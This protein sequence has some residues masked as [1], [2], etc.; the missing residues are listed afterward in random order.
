MT[1][2]KLQPT[3]ET[4]ALSEASS[5]TTQLSAA[6]RPPLAPVRQDERIIAL[7]TVRG[8]AL[9]GILLLNILAFALPDAAAYNP[10]IAGGATRWNFR[11]WF[12]VS[13]LFD[14]KLRTIFSMMFGASVY[15]LGERLSRKGAAGEAADIHYRRLLWMMLF[16]LI[17][18]Y[19][20]WWGDVLYYYAIAGLFLYPLR[21]LSAR[22]LLM[23]A[24]IML[25]AMPCRTFY[26][27]F[28][29]RDL[30]RQVLQVEA[31]QQAGKKLTAD[32]EKTKKEWNDL[33]SDVTPSADQLRED[34]ESHHGSWIA[35]FKGR[36]QMVGDGH[37]RLI[38]L[39]GPW[40][41]V[42]S[43]MLIGMAL[44]K[45]GV[46]SGERSYAFYGWMTTVCCGIGSS[47]AFLST[48]IPFKGGFTPEAFW[49]GFVFYQPG[50][51]AGL[52]YC[53]ILIMMVK[54]GVLRSFTSRLAAVG[55]TAFTNYI[56]TTVICTTIFENYGFGL[57]GKLQRWQLYAIVLGVWILQMAASPIWL[58]YYRFGPMEWL[59]R[60]LTYWKKQPM[61][62]SSDVRRTKT[63]IKAGL[64]TVAG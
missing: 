39:P 61:R 14:G 22:A 6:H 37:G 44:I 23:A 42:V 59:W 28:H 45:M 10:N 49:L 54:A 48:W 16:G 47:C 51:L 1:L 53:A 36:A 3:V 35:L 24:A 60:S 57:Y 63:P 15:M 21:K 5:R 40:W 41:D 30:H 19:L 7:D 50:R 58:R 56:L 55:Q 38:Y 2:G 12:L 31:D 18:A 8:F 9:L 20:L 11:I 34:Y 52:G 27:Y 64:A 26:R 32:Q 4:A 13:V 46:L 33:V 17:H 29:L 43:M 25:L 62:R